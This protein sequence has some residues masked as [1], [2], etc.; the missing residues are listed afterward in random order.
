MR[1]KLY[2]QPKTK[3]RKAKT[4]EI[5]GEKTDKLYS[6]LYC[7]RKVCEIHY[8]TLYGICIECYQELIDELEDLND[9]SIM[10]SN[11]TNFKLRG[12]EE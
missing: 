2:V 7:G 5:C 9:N 1:S 3:K 12:F 6:C 4:C 11:T 8:M 10:N